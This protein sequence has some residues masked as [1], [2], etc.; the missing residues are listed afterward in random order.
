MR[1]LSLTSGTEFSMGRGRNWRVIHPDM[2]ASSITLNHALHD[3]G[4]EFVQHVHDSSDDVIVVLD[5]SVSLRQGRAY[6]PAVAG[7]AL[8]IPSGEVHGTVNT[9]N[10]VAR[11]ISFQSPPDMAL[12]RGERNTEENRRP[13][14]S[15]G[16]VSRILVV[17][18]S[19]GSPDFRKNVEWRRVFGPENGAQ[20]MILEFGSFKENETQ[21]FLE[22][23]AEGVLVV[24][25]GKFVLKKPGEV[26]TELGENAVVFLERGETFSVISRSDEGRIL[27]CRALERG[28]LND[29]P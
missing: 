15:E 21:K 5:G 16:H 28:Q 11:M 4:N 18:M 23:G 17:R 6:T 13:V 29:N 3:I 12:Y 22:E 19:S 26:S 14:P 9:G 10:R 24:I 27:H 7:E 1:I 8:Y 2:G 25:H 20:K